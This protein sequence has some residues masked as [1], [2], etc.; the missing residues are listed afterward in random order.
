MSGW[1]VWGGQKAFIF[2]KK[3]IICGHLTQSWNSKMF[4]SFRRF[5]FKFNFF[6]FFFLNK[7]SD[8]LKFDSNLAAIEEPKT[9]GH[10]NV[11]RGSSPPGG[12]C[13]A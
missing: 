8:R 11:L 2:Q 3:E 9:D 5:S 4:A 1:G 13:T 10:L 6:L 7:N 12:T